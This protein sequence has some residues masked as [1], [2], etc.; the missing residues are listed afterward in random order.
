VTVEENVLTGGFGSSVSSLLQ[1]SGIN[2]VQLSNIGIADEFV[3]H[4]TQTILRAKYGLDTEGIV[5]HVLEMLGENKSGLS[6][7]VEDKTRTA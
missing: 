3:E 4:G 2:D 7:N 5:K 1:E 6:L